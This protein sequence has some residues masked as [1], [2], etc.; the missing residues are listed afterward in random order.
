MAK[1]VYINNTMPQAHSEV[2]H[3]CSL[4]ETARSRNSPNKRLVAADI[5]TGHGVLAALVTIPCS[6]G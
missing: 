1:D 6:P 3:L 2:L 4:A 5:E